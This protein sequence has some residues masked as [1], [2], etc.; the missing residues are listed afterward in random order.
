M[1]GQGIMSTGDFPCSGTGFGGMDP[2]SD[3]GVNWILTARRC[4]Y[5]SSCAGVVGSFGDFPFTSGLVI[6]IIF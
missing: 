1:E 2:W 3:R 6:L 5:L 4:S